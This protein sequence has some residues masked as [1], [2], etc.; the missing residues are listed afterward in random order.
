MRLFSSIQIIVLVLLGLVT[1]SA[2]RAVDTPTVPSPLSAERQYELEQRRLVMTA[3][4]ARLR[5]RLQRVP[6]NIGDVRSR[7]RDIKDKNQGRN[8]TG[9]MFRNDDVDNVSS[10]EWLGGKP[11]AVTTLV[12]FSRQLQ[13][14]GIDFIFVPQPNQIQLHAHELFPDMAADAELWPRY[15]EMV[16]RLLEQDVEVVDLV[17]AFQAYTGDGDVVHHYDHHWGSDGMELAARILAE[18]MQRYRV[19]RDGVAG[20]KHFTTRLTTTPMPSELFWHNNIVP[21]DKFLRDGV[22]P[23]WGIPATYQATQILY[24]GKPLRTDLVMSNRLDPVLVMGDSSVYHLSWQHG[25][26]AAGFPEHLSMALGFPVAQRPAGAA[27]PITPQRYAREFARQ[28]PQPRVLIESMV[29][30]YHKENW[31]SAD[32]PAAGTTTLE[33]VDVISVV[34]RVQTPSAPPD[35]KTTT[36]ADCLS[37]TVFDVEPGEKPAPKTLLVSQW[38]MHDRHLLEAAKIA[39]GERYRLTLL[40]WKEAVRREPLLGAAMMRDDTGMLD[41][42]MFWLLSATR[43]P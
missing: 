21:L 22:Q 9:Y 13:E 19:V 24:D 33:G 11:D 2:A 31:P 12:S 34:A 32:L 42:P 43:L 30:G 27:G 26:E 14:R 17:D 29:T 41:V 23:S 20:R 7:L 25:G 18:R 10:N 15:T 4:L 35:P 39:A 5:T 37:I 6:A 16:I 1:F 28:Q 3:D 40:P 38:V 8:A 36:Y